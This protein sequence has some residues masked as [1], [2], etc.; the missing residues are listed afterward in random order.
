MDIQVI[1][2]DTSMEPWDIEKTISSM[3]KAGLDVDN[4]LALA[5]SI[6]NWASENLVDGKIESTK[7]RDKVIEE[8]LKVDEI[9][10][11]E[12]KLYKK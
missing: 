10:A 9:A 7:I 4:A 11:E 2:R 12:Y 3:T 5:Q 6:A 8:M 1:K